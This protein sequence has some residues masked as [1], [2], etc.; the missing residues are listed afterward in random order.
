MT[1][2]QL[3]ENG[4]RSAQTDFPAREPAGDTPRRCFCCRLEGPC[5]CGPAACW[6]CGACGFHCV[7]PRGFVTCECRRVDVDVD[8]ARD[9]SVH[10]GDDSTNI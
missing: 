9:C 10:G 5:G 6:E 1:L 7:C 3:A 4:C 8:D 2:E